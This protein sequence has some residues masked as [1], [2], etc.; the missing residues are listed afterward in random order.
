[1]TPPEAAIWFRLKGRK[2]GEIMFRHQALCDGFFF[3]FFCAKA[4]LAI[5]IDGLIHDTLKQ[6]LH[7]ER[8]DAWMLEKGIVTYRIPASEVMADPDEAALGIW[9]MA[10]DRSE[11]LKP[12]RR[13]KVKPV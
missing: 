6:A 5:E 9:L 12:V 10:R 3:D 11:S 8:R 13:K 2:K 1:M 7:D 4:R